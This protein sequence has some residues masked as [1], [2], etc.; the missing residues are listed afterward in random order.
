MVAVLAAGAGY[1]LA[2]SRRL[3]R[4]GGEAAADGARGR[5]LGR[6]RGETADLG[7][8][9]LL[10]CVPVTE[11]SLQIHLAVASL[12]R[13]RGESDDAIRIHRHVLASDGFAAADGLRAR[14]QME[15][16][17]DFLAAGLLD[18]AEAILQDLVDAG[19]APELHPEEHLLEVYQR[20]RDWRK[21]AELARRMVAG[22]AQHLSRYLAHYLC[23]LAREGDGGAN[24]GQD[25]SIALYEEALTVDPGCV[26]AMLALGELAMRRGDH[27]GAM[28]HYDRV[29]DHDPRFLSEAMAGLDAVHRARGSLAEWGDRLA[30]LQAA[31][32]SGAVIVQR[33]RVLRGLGR[34]DEART[35]LRGTLASRP[36][37][38]LFG[39]LIDLE[40]G[41][42]SPDDGDALHGYAR[43]W[44]ELGMLYRCE[45]C[46][47]SAHELM[48]SCPSCQR[49][50]SILP[51]DPGSIA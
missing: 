44:T 47:F 12:A 21:A 6:V 2:R 22:G 50:N 40:R 30:E 37:A 34:V 5:I 1:L 16:V 36:T 8:D 39:E 13:D 33:A 51:V 10:R 41:N 20:E 31:H 19:E 32:G 46:G 45:Q 27:D 25:R 15:L 11:E 38:P 9:Y 17:R 3:P 48:W 43:T 24:S 23:E 4:Q 7:V 18:R 49:W 29:I 42:E 14:V 26:R 28:R 35:L